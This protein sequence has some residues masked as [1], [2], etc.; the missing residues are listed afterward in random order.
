MAD[1][2]KYPFCGAELYETDFIEYS[3]SNSK[4]ILWKEHLFIEIVQ[5]LI[6][7]KKA[8]DELGKISLALTVAE[9][10]IGSLD[11][12]C[13]PQEILSEITSI[14]KQDNE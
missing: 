14:T 12:Y 9:E 3:C 10:F 7:G 8:Q 13:H 6:D 2:L 4:C 5:A 11:E 1:K